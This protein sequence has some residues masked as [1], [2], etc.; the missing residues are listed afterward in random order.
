MKARV[1]YIL[2]TSI[3]I[4]VILLMLVAGCAPGQQATGDV[5][6]LPSPKVVEPKPGEEPCGCGTTNRAP[7]SAGDY[8]LGLIGDL[9][10]DH[11]PK[12]NETARLSWCIKATEAWTDL[13]AWVQ[14][15]WAS[16]KPEDGYHLPM[17]KTL[18]EILVNGTISYKG[19]LADDEEKHFE[20]IIK[21]PREGKWG[22]SIYYLGKTA[23]RDFTKGPITGQPNVIS[24]GH[25]S[26]YITNDY[27]Q[28]GI[29]KDHSRRTGFQR[30]NELYPV[31]TYIDVDEPPPFNEPVELVY[32][33]GSTRDVQNVKFD[34]YFT[35]YEDGKDSVVP[36]EKIVIGS[37]SPKTMDSLSRSE[38][39]VSALEQRLVWHQS[40]KSDRQRLM[41]ELPFKGS[42]WV[43]FPWEGDWEITF[44]VREFDGKPGSSANS[45]LYFNVSSKGST[46]GW[47]EKHDLI[48]Q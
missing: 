1:N 37:S 42:I 40:V 4:Y 9:A 24:G 13:N 6:N 7:A 8:R 35:Y 14:F 27:A 19:S 26:I 3:S 20:A 22:A 16:G 48:Q 29:P 11:A 17:S 31:V 32:A 43:S 25:Q 15:S 34:L 33:A 44:Y 41:E 36:R 39:L 12:A 45:H 10:I 47:R 5:K 30:P 18:E 38:G 21:F 2:S 28:F 46:W 23:T